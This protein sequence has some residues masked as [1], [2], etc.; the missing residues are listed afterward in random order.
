LI[1]RKL[2]H[3]SIQIFEAFP[4]APLPHRVLNN[5]FKSRFDMPKEKRAKEI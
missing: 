5:N 1:L 2:G 4:K 3:P